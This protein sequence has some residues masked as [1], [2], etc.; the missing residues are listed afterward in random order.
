MITGT[1]IGDINRPIITFLPGIR[2]RDRPSAAAVPIVI[3]S[4]P[5]GTTIWTLVAS[6]SAHA[7]SPN[8]LRYHCNENPGGGKVRKCAELK[9]MITT[10]TIGATRNTTSNVVMVR[11][12]T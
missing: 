12:N 6:E 11:R 7:G 2:L 3:A 10:M 8:R 1:T 5:L 9:E 4:T